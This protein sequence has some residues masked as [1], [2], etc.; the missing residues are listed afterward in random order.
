MNYGQR[1]R[2][3]AVGMC[4]GSIRAFLFGGLIAV[5]TTGVAAGQTTTRPP[6]GGVG[7]PPDAM[8]FYVAQGADACGPGCSVWIAAEGTVQFDTNRRLIAILERERRTQAPREHLGV[9][10]ERSPLSRP[11]LGSPLIRAFGA[12]SFLIKKS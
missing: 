8:I 9:V 1:L 4:A 12:A 7:S 11:D 10:I 6:V 2:I 5:I 3:R